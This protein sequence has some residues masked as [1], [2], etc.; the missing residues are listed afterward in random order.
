MAWGSWICLPFAV[1]ALA[2]PQD[3]VAVRFGVFAK[4]GTEQCL[5]QWGPTAEYLTGKISGNT[6]IIQPLEYEEIGPSVAQGDIDF[7]LVN[8]SLYIELESSCGASRIAN[9]DNLSLGKPHTLYAGVIFRSGHTWCPSRR[10][11]D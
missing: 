9:L 6:F 11:L 2:S 7:V 10:K 5:E 4:R 1:V 8:P 3:F